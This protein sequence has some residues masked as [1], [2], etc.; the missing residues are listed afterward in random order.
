[1]SMFLHLI[2]V[3]ILLSLCLVFRPVFTWKHPDLFCCYGDDRSSSQKA[4]RSFARSL[5]IVSSV[6][7]FR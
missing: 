1:M 4:T 7:M 3:Y 2:C 6:S 5:C